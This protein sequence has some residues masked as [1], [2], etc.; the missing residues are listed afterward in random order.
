MSIEGFQLNMLVV[1]QLLAFVLLRVLFCRVV[2]HYPAVFAVPD[3]LFYIVLRKHSSI[4]TYSDT[5]NINVLL[6]I[7]DHRRCRS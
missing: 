2:R 5:I 3:P 4:H 7:P 6:R 1:V